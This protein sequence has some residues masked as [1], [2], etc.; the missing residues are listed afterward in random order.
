MRNIS[1]RNDVMPLKDVLYRLA[2]RITLNREEAEDIVQDTLIK[3]W[4]KRDEWQDI[5]S[6]EA[7]SLTICRNLS[8][9]RIKRA[10][11]D[12]QQIN[13]GEHTDTVI[14]INPYERIVQKDSIEQVKHIIDGLPEKQKSCMQ[15]R[16]FEGKSYK[17]I[18]NIMDISE[19]QVKINIFRAR[20]TVKKQFKEI[21]KY[22]L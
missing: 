15:L 20:Q 7:Y 11:N 21:D 22:G 3:V 19:E 17:D 8:L 2:L 4:N 14:S 1:F 13:E 16:D 6:I 10:G 5:K 12:T 9:D 18:A